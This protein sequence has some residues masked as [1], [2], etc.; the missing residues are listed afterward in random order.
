MA[1]SIKLAIADITFEFISAQCEPISFIKRKFKIFLSTAHPDVKISLKLTETREGGGEPFIPLVSWN[2]SALSART[3]F[4]DVLTDFGKNTASIS[5]GPDTGMF[6][7]L[8][9]FSSVF[10][11]YRDGFLLHASS[12]IYRRNAYL[13]FGPSGSG[14]STI[15]RLSRGAV[16]SD[17]TTGVRTRKDRCGAWSTPFS[18]EFDGV[19]SNITAPIKA[20]FLLKKDMVFSHRPMSRRE[21]I[22]SLFESVMMPLPDP[23]TADNLFRTFAEF[24][25]KIP[26]Y[27]FHFRPEPGIWRYIYEHIE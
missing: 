9:F 25:K 21:S 13:F 15:A 6:N 16:L 10:L 7:V 17:E 11:M 4:F 12:V 23:T 18:G 26:C 8:K 3:Q 14:K 22:Q 20:A 27:E 19:R 5:V 1:Y 2:G 24:T